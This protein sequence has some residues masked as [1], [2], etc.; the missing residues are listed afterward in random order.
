ML[1]KSL[2]ISTSYVN[3]LE[4]N[5]RSVSASVLLSLLETYGVD[6]RDIA[7]DADTSRLA[8]LNASFNDP[9][10]ESVRP[11]LN[12]LRAAMTHCPDLVESFAILYQSYQSMM[13]HL[14]SGTGEG[15]A[16]ELTS[17]SPEALVHA[18]FRSRSNYFEA[19]EV[20]ADKFFGEAEPDRDEVYS[21]VKQRLRDRLGLEV[22]L[23][24]VDQLQN[25]L[26]LY[27]SASNKILLSEA[28]DYPN[29]VFQ[30]LHVAC[31]VEKND[32]LDDIIDQSGI[33]DERGRAR[34]RVELANYYAAAI[35]MPYGPFLEEALSSKY[36]F[37]H[38]ATRFGASFEQ[39][40]HRAATLQ[41]PGSAGVPL[42]FFRIDRAGNVSKRLNATEFQL[43]E[44]GGACP[45]LHVH[46]C[47]RTPD[48][49]TPQLVEMP[50][51]S[52]YLIFARTVNRPIATRHNQ[53][54]KL[55]IAVGCDVE[56]AKSI[57][58]AEELGLDAGR[59]TE[60]G[61]NCRICP[62]SHCEQRAQA[63]LA[64]SP[65]LNTNRRGVTRHDG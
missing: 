25:S 1:A 18:F 10:F 57:G 29:R 28:L 48:R 61:I 45:R 53:D 40:C 17:A 31:L 14:L 47:F 50:D 64:L 37:D 24:S 49:I 41:R 32:L 16:S 13:E 22:N 4:N 51:S 58:Y 8:D 23:A 33:T 30:L 52:R 35:T 63:G 56:H 21:Y 59:A 7:A 6:W 65:Q 62:R 26:R 42:F 19:L 38:L 3:L 55:A 36:D 11:D 15:S 9:L 27:D 34:C 60:I 5:E 46:N 20:E 43:A 12:Q 54:N 44:Y 2:G 39:A